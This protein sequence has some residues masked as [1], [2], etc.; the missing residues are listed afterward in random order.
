MGACL[1]RKAELLVLLVTLLSVMLQFDASGKYK[2]RA[3]Q[4]QSG[5]QSYSAACFLY[6]LKDSHV[7]S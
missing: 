5:I 1:V 4:C 2:Q 6:E 3:R 7:P